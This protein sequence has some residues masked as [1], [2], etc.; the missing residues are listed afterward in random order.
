MKLTALALLCITL[1]APLKDMADS[2]SD[3]VIREKPQVIRFLA[4]SGTPKPE[5]VVFMP[6]DGGW[7]GSA[8]EMARMVASLGY[9]V[10]GF[11]VKTYLTNFTGKT[12]LS[13]REMAADLRALGAWVHQKS[14]QPVIY[15]GWSQG[16]NMSLLAGVASKPDE[17][18]RGVLAIGITDQAVLGWRFID[19]LTYFTRQLP[20]EPMFS[21]LPHI[22]KLTP[23]PLVMVAP[24]HDEYVTMETTRQIFDAAAQPK[25]IFIVEADDH[26]FFGGRDAFLQ[27]LRDGLR[28]LHDASGPGP[29]T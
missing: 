10:Y 1:I 15:A 19:N 3:W 8:I 27:A 24:T 28:F 18:C 20:N 6:G 23:L 21:P 14:G 29:R 2:R 5:A 9:N 22:G 12:T 13:E 11:D 26:R 17:Y 16:A 25:R 7:I 4:A